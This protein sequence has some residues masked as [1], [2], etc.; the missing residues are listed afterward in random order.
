MSALWTRRN[1]W[2][3]VATALVLSALDDIVTHHLWMTVWRSFIGGFPPGYLDDQ[4]QQEMMLDPEPIPNREFY[5][6]HVPHN[7]VQNFVIQ[8]AAYYWQSMIDRWIPTRPLAELPQ[9]KEKDK[10]VRGREEMEM[11]IM[12]KLI[13]EGRV[14]PGGIK[15]RNVLLR[16]LLDD[17]LGT[18]LFGALAF[19]L[20][21]ATRLHGPSHII[22][23]FPGAMAATFAGYFFSASPLF[24]IIGHAYVPA[25]QRLQFWAAAALALNVTV[26]VLLRPVVPWFMN[27]G[28]VQKFFKDIMAQNQLNDWWAREMARHD[29]ERVKIEQEIRDMFANWNDTNGKG[30]EL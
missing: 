18:A 17:T 19:L 26:S 7:L 6:D 10:E 15:W 20:H 4:A 9:A 1:V 24:S 23:E 13:A 3:A 29:V 22:Q 21:C 12:Q 25:H 16:W 11:E 5:L 14:K 28:F 27:L 30:D 2:T 8:F